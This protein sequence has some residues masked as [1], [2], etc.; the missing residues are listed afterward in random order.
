VDRRALYSAGRAVRDDVLRLDVSPR[1]RNLRSELVSVWAQP[2]FPTRRSHVTTTSK[3][4]SCSPTGYSY[5]LQPRHHQNMARSGAATPDLE[6][7]AAQPSPPWLTSSM[8]IITGT[9]QKS[10]TP[11]SPRRPDHPP[12]RRPSA[13]EG[14][15]EISVRPQQAPPTDCHSPPSCPS[16]VD[17]CCRWFDAAV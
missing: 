4:T 13:L 14:L 12:C 10:A 9:R 15:V 5:R 6:L 11:T 16:T 7:G 1:E 17:A 8:A 3:K 2:D